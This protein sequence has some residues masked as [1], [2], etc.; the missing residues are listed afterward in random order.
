VGSGIVA[1]YF[2]FR[3]FSKGVV[4]DQ[5]GEASWNGFTLKLVKVG[6]GIFFAL[7]GTGIVVTMTWER[8]N[9]PVAI[10]SGSDVAVVSAFSGA[11]GT[12]L[13]QIIE[14]TRV[15]K[16]GLRDGSITVTQAASFMDRAQR[17]LARV[18]LGES[19][20]DRCSSNAVLRDSSECSAYRRL[21]E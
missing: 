15:A 2:G 20:F 4:V 1:L 7:F 18:R 12:A 21:V 6:P 9:I 3:L 11:S 16:S 13:E 19:L 17:T 8:V 5:S 10:G 14:E